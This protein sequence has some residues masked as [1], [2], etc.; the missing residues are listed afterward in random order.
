MLRAITEGNPLRALVYA[1]ASADK[2][3]SVEDQADECLEFCEEEQ[4]EVIKVLRENERSASRYAT[5]ERPEFKKVLAAMRA[6][7]VDVLVTWEN[8]RAHR[9]L[10]VYVELRQICEEFNV[11]WA[12]GGEVYDMHDPADRQATAQDA[13]RS[14]SE[15]DGISTRVAR[16]V[17]R[18]A[19]KGLWHGALQYGYKREYD[20]DT[21][22]VLRQVVDPVTSAVVRQIV[23]RLLAGDSV[24]SIVNDL[25]ERGVPCPRRGIWGASKIRHLALNK[26][27]AGKRVHKGEVI[28]DGQWPAIVTPTEHAALTAL[29]THPSRRTNKDGTRV[30]HLLSGIATCGQCGSPVGRIRADGFEAYACRKNR[31]V[32]RLQTRVDAF[33]QEALL[34]ALEDPASADLF[35]V[36]Q[37]D[38]VASAL[39]EAKELRARLESFYRQ[40]A[41]GKLSETGLAAIEAELLPLVQKAEEKLE[42][43]SVPAV[44]AGMVGP[45]ARQVWAALTLVQRRAAIR[46]VMQP[47]IM[48]V[49]RG[50]HV[51]GL[52]G[53]E[54]NFFGRPEAVAS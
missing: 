43:A 23:D 14:E 10:A 2:E 28:G 24:T 20:P 27:V 11:L 31:H 9:D 38:D 26:V 18:R 17:R 51:K 37:Q 48:P 39:D 53:V 36:D 35:Q 12:Y 49:G 42:Q 44:L 7:Q 33:V 13:V 30:K 50:G 21:G 40:A 22:T 25:N 46:A 54:P 29:L 6:G 32:V 5:K 3:K 41:L 19:K 16:G 47:R 15:S 8:S 34:T 45:N 52:L 4:F 1:R